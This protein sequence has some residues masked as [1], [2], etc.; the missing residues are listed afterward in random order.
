MK[1]RYVCE[2]RESE[3]VMPQTIEELRS[4]L[5]SAERRLS[6]AEESVQEAEEEREMIEGDIDDLETKTNA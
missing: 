3:D 4:D 1:V 2:P 6:D 5:A